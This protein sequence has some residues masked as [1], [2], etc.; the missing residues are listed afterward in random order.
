MQAVFI[1]LWEKSALLDSIESLDAYL[2]QCVK[3]QCLNRLKALKIQD[4][5][6]LLMT[7]GLL[8][9]HTESEKMDPAL[10]DQLQRAI[11]E[12]PEGIRQIIQLK[13][14]ENLQISEIAKFLNISEN[15][16]KTQL[17]RGKKKLREGLKLT[18]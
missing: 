7:E 2:F 4:Q 8:Q 10:Q 15:T 16:V 3:N 11:A 6:N 18:T 9:Y 13:Y 5:Y 12:L 1:K 14:A 17:K